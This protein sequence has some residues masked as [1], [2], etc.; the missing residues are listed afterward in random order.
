MP[1]YT[2][3]IDFTSNDDEVLRY[4]A[5]GLRNM[6]ATLVDA[7]TY[8]GDRIFGGAY[9]NDR[10]VDAPKK[11][12]ATAQRLVELANHIEDIDLQLAQ[13]AEDRPNVGKS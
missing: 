2:I 3:K 10:A 4:V 11:I 7:S 5:K 6:R 1:D 13:L 8:F 12:K 9:S